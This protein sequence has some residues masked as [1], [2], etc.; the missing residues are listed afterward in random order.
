MPMKKNNQLDILSIHSYHQEYPWTITQ[1]EAFKKQLVH[2]LPEYKV[3]FTSEYLDT[4]HIQPSPEYK[5]NF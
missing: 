2:N 5:K 4:K 1:Y 3:H